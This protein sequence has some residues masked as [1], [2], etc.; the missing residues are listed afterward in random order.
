MSMVRF[1]LA[2]LLAALPA[3]AFAQTF[4]KLTG[5]VV[6]AANLL[7]PAQEAELT[8]LSEDIQ[9]A[10]TRQFVVATI[11][12]LQGYPIE[13]YGYRLLRA[14]GIGQKDA[15]NGIILI[16]A[17]KERLVR[18]EVGY[19]LE[20][21]MTDGFSGL[22]ID[23]AIRPKFRAG[24]MGGGIIAGAAEIAEQMKLP[25]EAGEVRAKAKLDAERKTTVQ[26]GEASPRRSND[27]F[28]IG[29]FGFLFVIIV[30]V[31]IF[32]SMRGA[33]RRGRRYRSDGTSVAGEI[34]NI[35][36]WTA[37]DA[38]LRSGGR[39]SGGGWSGGSGWGGGGSSGGSSW[40]GGG[41]GFSGG[42]GS[43]GGGGATGSW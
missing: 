38:A 10:S 31:I 41:G 40:G 33:S 23:R 17:P 16:V 35:L 12:D 37:V 9:K 21:I 4:P 1:L 36:L 19:G 29:N 22:I 24:D 8:K 28:D 14:W 27:G 7:D 15:N 43:G 2:L 3:S 13:D 32:A 26:Q 42:G 18:I 39:R 11:P 5:R 25:L 20:P 6:D 34:G 30:M